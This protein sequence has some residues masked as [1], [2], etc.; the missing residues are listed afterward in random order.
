MFTI[1]DVCYGDRKMKRIRKSE[2]L[3]TSI[4]EMGTLIHLGKDEVKSALNSRKN[5]VVASMLAIL[6]F[7]VVENIVYGPLRYGASCVNDFVQ[8]GKFL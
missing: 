7:V 1:V 8:I 3:Q 4:Y 2:K 6:A 5:I